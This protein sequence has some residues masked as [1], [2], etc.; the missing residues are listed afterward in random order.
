MERDKH[1]E[2]TKVKRDDK[3]LWL[4]G[5]SANPLGRPKGK[6]IKE[7]VR[8]YLDEHPED[9]QAFV[10]HFVE[11]NKELAWQMMEGRPH[12]SEDHQVDT[13]IHISIPRA[14]AKRF[15]INETKD[16]L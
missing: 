11:N 12:Q 15:K 9:M 3:G 2:N 5:Q 16:E 8:A 4:K 1:E 6:T 14:V 7:Q 13:T 10:K